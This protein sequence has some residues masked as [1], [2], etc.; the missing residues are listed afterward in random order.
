MVESRSKNLTGAI[1][2][3]R[4]D[5]TIYLNPIPSNPLLPS[6]AVIL[7]FHTPHL[8]LMPHLNNLQHTHVVHQKQPRRNTRTRRCDYYRN[9]RRD[10]VLPYISY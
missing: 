4:T 5:S 6:L 3:Q 2:L 7:P 9:F 1:H 8:P 10:T